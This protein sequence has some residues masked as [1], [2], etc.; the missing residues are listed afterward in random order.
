MASKRKGHPCPQ[1]WVTEP[2]FKENELKQILRVNGRAGARLEIASVAGCVPEASRWCCADRIL[3]P[4][5]R[6]AA[7]RVATT[8]VSYLHALI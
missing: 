2:V 4:H 7:L 5:P 3:S 8:D 1:V 6:R